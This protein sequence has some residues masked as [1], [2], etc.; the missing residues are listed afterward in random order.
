[1]TFIETLL[2]FYISARLKNM[3]KNLSEYMIPLGTNKPENFLW[4]W[5]LSAD[6][7]DY[8]DGLDMKHIFHFYF[9]Y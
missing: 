6:N 8:I 3:I 1:M 9:Q 4:V 2:P 7:G 5:A